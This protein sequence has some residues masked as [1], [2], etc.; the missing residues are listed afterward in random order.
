MMIKYALFKMTIMYAWS[1]FVQV[2]A[3]V[4]V[5]VVLCFILILCIILYL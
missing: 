4:R 2:N 5:T 1:T 3:S